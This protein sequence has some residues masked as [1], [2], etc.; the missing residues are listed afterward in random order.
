MTEKK[1]RNTLTKIIRIKEKAKKESRYY[2]ETVFR[3]IELKIIKKIK[4]L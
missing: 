4:E 2:D 1:L 3:C